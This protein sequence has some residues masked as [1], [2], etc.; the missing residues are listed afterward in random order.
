MC[1]P[2]LMMLCIH[3]TEHVGMHGNSGCN[4]LYM[5]SSATAIALLAIMMTGNLVD[6]IYADGI[7]T[8]ASCIETDCSLD[9]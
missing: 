3:T 1:M 4:M 7:H 6:C 9:P 2:M 8:H 5:A